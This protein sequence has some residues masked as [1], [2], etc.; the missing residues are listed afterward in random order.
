MAE[1]CEGVRGCVHVA[2]R[3]I[4][5]SSTRSSISLGWDWACILLRMCIRG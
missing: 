5:L 4:G 3:C 2:D 1:G